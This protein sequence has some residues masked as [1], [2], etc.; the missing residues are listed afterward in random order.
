MSPLTIAHPQA[1]NIFAHRDFDVASFVTGRFVCSDKKETERMLWV[2]QHFLM[3]FI[4]I[5]NHILDTLV[6]IIYSESNSHFAAGLNIV[7]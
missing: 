6:K 4:S 7:I 1:E 5:N 3:E 2:A